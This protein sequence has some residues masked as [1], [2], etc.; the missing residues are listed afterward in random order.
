MKIEMRYVANAD[1]IALFLTGDAWTRAFW[2]T[3]RQ[4]IRLVKGCEEQSAA[5]GEK[6]LSQ[7]RGRK[8]ST[9]DRLHR[10]D[11]Q[12][13]SEPVLARIRL[14]YLSD[15]LKLLFSIDGEKEQFIM[16]LPDNS[17]KGFQKALKQLAERAHW[18]VEAGL[19]RIDATQRRYSKLLH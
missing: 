18:E 7:T 9:E 10:D 13:D 16:T 19:K 12:A 3:R 6:S 8:Q 5:V 17:A 14:K 4:C 11:V 1:R 2:I 15:G